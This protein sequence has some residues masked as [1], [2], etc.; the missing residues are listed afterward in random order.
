LVNILK[1]LKL[2]LFLFPEENLTIFNIYY[3]YIL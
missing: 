2:A 3:N 1:E